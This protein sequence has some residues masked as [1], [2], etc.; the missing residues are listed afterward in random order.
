MIIENRDSEMTSERAKLLPCL[1]QN[2][3]FVLRD[4]YCAVV[5]I[6][7]PR[8]EDGGQRTDARCSCLTLRETPTED[9]GVGVGLKEADYREYPKGTKKRL[10]N[11][12]FK[13]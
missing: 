7:E 10:K 13:L 11:F 8:P 2:D 6:N 5:N 12:Y 9:I 4:A 1:A 3:I